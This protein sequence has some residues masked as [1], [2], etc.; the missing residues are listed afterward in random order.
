[1]QISRGWG[2][3]TALRI[4][5]TSWNSSGACSRRIVISDGARAGRA[6]NGLAMKITTTQPTTSGPK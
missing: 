1:M 5:S 6:R 2:A 3:P 4:R